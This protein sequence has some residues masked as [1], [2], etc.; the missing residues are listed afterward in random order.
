VDGR[1]SVRSLYNGGRSSRVEG[2]F[3]PWGPRLRTSVWVIVVLTLLW[4][5]SCWIADVMAALE[6]VDRKEWR[7]VWGVASL[8]FAGGPAG[9]PH[10]ALDEVLVELVT[11]GLTARAILVMPKSRSFTPD[12][13]ASSR[14]RPLAVYG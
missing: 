14:R 3:T 10:G 9:A 12:G 2:A 7:R 4:P 1:R 11:S 6:Q 8:G 13:E 5:R